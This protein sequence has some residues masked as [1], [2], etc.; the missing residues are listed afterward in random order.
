[1]RSH[2]CLCVCMCISHRCYATAWLALVRCNEHIHSNRG[3]VEI[4]SIGT[5]HI[6]W[7]ESK[8][9]SLTRASCS[10][11]FP[12]FSFI[13]FSTLSSYFLPLH[14]RLIFRCFL[15][16]FHYCLFSLTSFSLHL[17]FLIRYSTSSLHTLSLLLFIMYL[18]SLSVLFRPLFL[19]TCSIVPSGQN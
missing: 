18:S 6:V 13:L 8:E 7:E 15:F 3:T 10:F 12:S 11:F 19:L 2:R 4:V 14:F 16:L 1:M 9:L 17:I 5:L